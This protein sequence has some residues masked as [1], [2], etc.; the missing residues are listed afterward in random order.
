MYHV[1][2]ELCGPAI[3]NEIDELFL[4]LRERPYPSQ[5]K[6]EKELPEDQL[7]LIHSFLKHQKRSDG[8]PLR[9]YDPFVGSGLIARYLHKLGYIVLHDSNRNFLDPTG[10]QAYSQNGRPPDYDF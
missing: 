4:K 3:T 7:E 8:K 5:E 10:P 6:E 1:Q 9:I 2:H